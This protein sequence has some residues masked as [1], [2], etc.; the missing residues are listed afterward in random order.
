MG[1]VSFVKR[2]VGVAEAQ[3]NEAVET[4]ENAD[5]EAMLKLEVIHDKEAIQKAYA[6]M[7]DYAGNIQSIEAGVAAG[8]KAVAQLTSDLEFFILENDDERQLKTAEQ[9]EEKETALSEA[10]ASLKE[11][12][13]DYEEQMADLKEAEDAVTKKDQ[14]LKTMQAKVKVSEIKKQSAQ[15]TTSVASATSI[16]SSRTSAAVQR[17]EERINRNEGAAKVASDRGQEGRDEREMRQRMAKKNARGILEKKKSELA[18]KAK[19]PAA[20]KK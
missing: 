3:A 17:L 10:Q 8:K 13:V 14:M 1:I 11:L 18:A 15:I 2:L 9:L 7:G 20:K 16:D 12:R 19:K 4:A 6:S 5:P